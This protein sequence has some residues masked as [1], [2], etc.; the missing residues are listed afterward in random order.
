MTTLRQIERGEF[1]FCPEIG[2]DYFYQMIK[3]SHMYSDAIRYINVNGHLKFSGIANFNLHDSGD[4]EA[5]I[6]DVKME[7]D[8]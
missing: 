6:I 3:K 4:K 8:L 1:F 7:A 2:G 5:I